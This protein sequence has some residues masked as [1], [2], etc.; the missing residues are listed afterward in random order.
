[1]QIQSTIKKHADDAGRAG[2][3]AVELELRPP[4]LGPLRLHL[5]REDGRINVHLVVEDEATRQLLLGHREALRL[6]MLEMGVRV[7]QFDVRRDG[8]RR[9]PMPRST[10]E[11]SLQAIQ[12]IKNGR[13]R[14]EE[15]PPVLADPQALVDVIA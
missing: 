13:N 12:V 14:R 6:R 3:V 5:V 7:G 4:A 15:G 10:S 8:G 11:F 1:M 9:D 2:R